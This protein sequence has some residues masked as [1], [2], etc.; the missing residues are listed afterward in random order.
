LDIAKVAKQVANELFTSLKA[1]K[2]T[3]GIDKIRQALA[4]Y[5]VGLCDWDK[6]ALESRTVRVLIEKV[7]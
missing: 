5:N 4:P 2:E 7:G 6:D 3:I 1:N